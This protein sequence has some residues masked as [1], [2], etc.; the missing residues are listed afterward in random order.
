MPPSSASLPRTRSPGI[1]SLARPTRFPRRRRSL[2]AGLSNASSASLTRCSWRWPDVAAKPRSGA[3]ML[4]RSA[5]PVHQTSVARGA[6]R[7]AQAASGPDQP[8][9]A[10]VAGHDREK[11]AS[12]QGGEGIRLSGSIR[13]VAAKAAST[14]LSGAYGARPRW[15]RML[16]IANCKSNAKSKN[17][18]SELNKQGSIACLMKSLR[19]EERS[20]SR[21]C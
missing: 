6:A 19:S 1:G 10:I 9:F 20:I 7:P 5:S 11:R 14:N 17:I 16:A 2:M 13:R 12:W 21:L 4:G 18:E 15:K 3:G 8:R